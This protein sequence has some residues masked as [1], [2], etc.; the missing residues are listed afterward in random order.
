[1]VQRSKSLTNGYEMVF[2]EGSAAPT[3]GKLSR[4]KLSK[5]F[6]EKDKEQERRKQKSRSSLTDEKSTV[7]L[8]AETDPERGIACRY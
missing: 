7:S 2:D 3:E 6:M 5:R 4:K 8:E 1:M